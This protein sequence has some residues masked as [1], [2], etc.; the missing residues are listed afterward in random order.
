MIARRI[1]DLILRIIVGIVFIFSGFVKAV[2]PFGS[3]YK[4]T[5]YFEAFGLD[6]LAPVALVLACILPALEFALGFALILNLLKKFTTWVLMGFVIY[7]TGLTFI[8]A[9]TNPISDC[10]CFGDALKISNWA[11]FFK[12]VVLLF[13]SVFLVWHNDENL[14]QTFKPNKQRI[15]WG[16]FLLFSLAISLYSIYYMPVLDFRPYKLGTNIYNQMTPP[17]GAQQDVYETTFFYEKDGIVKEFNEKNYPWE[18]STWHF[19]DSKTE[20]IKKGYEPPIKS[21]NILNNQGE[22]IGLDIILSKELQF[23]VVA[24]DLNHIN[25]KTGQKIKTLFEKGKEKNISVFMLSSSTP[26]SNNR[27]IYLIN[28]K[29][30]V[31]QADDIL[32]KSMIRANPGLFVLKDG[33]IIGK[34]NLKR[35]EITSGLFNSLEYS[36]SHQRIVENRYKILTLGLIFFLLIWG[37]IKLD[38]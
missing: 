9:V 35:L 29:I 23:F 16:I 25:N 34:Y 24:R 14:N 26:Q 32:L 2:D 4:F 13:M 8:I 3:A 5:D 31:Y 22:D 20:L 6:F 36:L 33:T 21:F 30:P 11:T 10:G 18:D 1:I 38:K 37:Y 19:V 15:L 17:E 7:F 27:F 12:N 28:S